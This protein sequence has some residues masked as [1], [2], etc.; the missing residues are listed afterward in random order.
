[1]REVRVL[2]SDESW[3]KLIDEDVANLV[4]G[5]RPAPKPRRKG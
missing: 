4:K 2:V 3:R 1:M 5:K